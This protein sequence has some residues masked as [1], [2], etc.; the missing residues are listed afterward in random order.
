MEF[1]DELG[2]IPKWTSSNPYQNRPSQVGKYVP[3]NRVCSKIPSTPPS[4]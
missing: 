3:L 2:Q 1:Y 4:A